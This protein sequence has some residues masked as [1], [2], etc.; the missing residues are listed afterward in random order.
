MTRD[1][2][3]L[4]APPQD[5]NGKTQH[6]PDCRLIEGVLSAFPDLCCEIEVRHVPYE[7][8]LRA[9]VPRGKNRMEGCPL[10]IRQTQGEAVMIDNVAEILSVLSRD[11][12]IPVASCSIGQS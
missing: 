4:L 8:L 1:T 2:L 3:L 5:G 12:R 9:P 7:M 10:M 6:C 11:Y